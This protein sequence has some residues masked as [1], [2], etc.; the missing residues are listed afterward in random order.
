MD[1]KELE[2]ILTEHPYLPKP[3]YVYMVEERVVQNIDHLTLVYKGATPKEERD[4]IALTPDADDVTVVHELLH[5]AGFDE[6]GAYLLAPR[7]RKIRK[8]IPPILSFE[9]HYREV[10]SPHP[11]VKVFERVK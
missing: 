7:L 11:K 5:L 6:A 8:I 9:V 10:D 2:K 3:K 4:R 1:I